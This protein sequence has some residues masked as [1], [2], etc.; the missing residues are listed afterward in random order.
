MQGAPENTDPSPDSSKPRFRP[1]PWEH[2]E[3][4]HDVEVWIEEHNQSMQQNIRPGETGYGVCFTLAEGGD[5]YMQTSSD[6]AVILDVT[7][8]AEWVSPL[9]AAVS[10]SE[11]PSSSLWI[12]PDDKLIQLVL[13]LSSLVASTTLVVGHQ[14]GTRQRRTQPYR[15]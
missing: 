9:L 6:G 1:R 11:A 12:L 8:D 2:L 15:R 13:G 14:F 4:P 10:Q 5:I 7:P 3:T